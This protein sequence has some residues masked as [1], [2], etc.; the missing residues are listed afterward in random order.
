MP[1]HGARLSTVV[2]IVFLG[3]AL[4]A[5][6]LGRTITLGPPPLGPYSTAVRAG[7][8]VHVSGTLGTRDDG[9]LA[10]PTVGD[11]TRAA[12]GRIAATLEASGSS[13]ADA[14]SMMV[15]LRRAGDF[16]AMNEVYRT[17]WPADPPT[18]TTVVADLPMAE[19]LV[20]ISAVAVARG[21][22]RVVV[23]PEGWTRSP[24]PYSYAVRS[25]DTLF[26]SGL[27]ARDV[28][29]NTAVQGDVA[30]QLDVIMQ[31]GAD[32]LRAA[33]LG[34][35]DV[36]SAKVFLADAADFQAMNEAYRARFGSRPPVRATVRA[37]LA[38]PSHTVEVTMVAVAGAKEAVSAGGRPNP[39]LSAA[40]RAGD[41][42]YVS[43]ML[44]ATDRTRGDAGAQT[45]EALARIDATLGAAGFSRADV[46]EGLVYL[47]DF[48]HYGAM[49][50]AY[51][52]FFGKDFPA[53]AT[54]GAG[55][56][57]PDGLVEIMVTAVKAP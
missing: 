48:A 50:D 1:T 21:G 49:N 22:E 43:G 51:R 52:A 15:Y 53:R 42:L 18:R 27:V 4:M 11:Q 5:D 13:L 8:F 32:I 56:F 29:A 2:V 7:G 9:R 3:A 20:E 17:F 10:G 33:G 54:V 24:N 39:N 30:A 23:H 36:V 25:G 12:L 31:N 14:V 28:H 55:L 38:S 40:I 37:A 35:D 45:R 44:G 57:N 47:T 19:A 41:R 6:Q 34:F 16:A 46:V 26:L